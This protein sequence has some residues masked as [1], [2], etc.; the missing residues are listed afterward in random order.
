MAPDP[1][2]DKYSIETPEQMPLEFA[3]AGIGSRF[4]AMAID[5]LIQLGFAVVVFIAASIAS[6]IW[7]Q[8]GS[9]LWIVGA[10]IALLFL[11]TFAYFAIF[12]IWWNGQTPGKRRAGI[13]VIKDSGRP[14]TVAE[15]IG[16]N[17]LRIV[18][19]LPVFYALGVLIAFLNSRNKRLGDF[20]AGS[21]VIRETPLADLKPEWQNARTA[22]PPLS[23]L[24]SPLSAEDLNLID[25]FLNRRSHL[26][27][28]VRS[29]IANEI[30]E[31][32]RAKLP[33]QDLLQSPGLT[34]ESVLEWLGS[35][36][37]TMGR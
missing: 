26:T 19:Q 12:E 34:T 20:I 11:L 9:R 27:A 29:R 2:P 36:R 33:A 7:P 32:I 28:D 17:L 31:R 35:Q 21:I 13:R 25:A 30:F 10:A 6:A 23:P 3:I 8:P 24:V 1:F 37:R 14:L 4:L 16:R 18:D 5:T 22:P 15:T